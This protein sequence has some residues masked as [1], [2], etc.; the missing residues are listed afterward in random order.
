VTDDPS[1]PDS[2]LLRELAF[3][4]WR[5]LLERDPAR[6]A[7]AA[8][9]LERWVLPELGGLRADDI[10]VGM[11]V[12]FTRTLAQHTSTAE[13]R[14]ALYW[15]RTLLLFGGVVLRCEHCGSAAFEPSEFGS[16]VVCLRCGRVAGAA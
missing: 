16:E 11:T 13:A 10:R 4:L 8:A 5:A 6:A 3:D 14:E 12:S 15:L 2:P 1:P 7:R 9:V